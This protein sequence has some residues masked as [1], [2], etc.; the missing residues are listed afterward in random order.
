MR[1]RACWIPKC[2]SVEEMDLFVKLCELKNVD[3]EKA[4][5]NRTPFSTKQIVIHILS[6]RSTPK[7]FKSS[8]VLSHT[9]FYLDGNIQ[10]HIIIIREFRSKTM[11]SALNV[12]L[13]NA[14]RFFMTSRLKRT[15]RNLTLC[16][17]R[18]DEC[19]FYVFYIQ[20]VYFLVFI[21]SP[22]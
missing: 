17:T 6:A 2:A 8:F 21:Y 5:Y 22:H 14:S 3:R 20:L 1:G 16:R 13:L 10:L 18:Y 4:F 11:H 7:S 19:I 15:G 9:V 12:L